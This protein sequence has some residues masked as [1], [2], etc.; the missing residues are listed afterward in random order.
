[1]LIELQ[2]LRQVVPPNVT[3]HQVIEWYM[4]AGIASMAPQVLPCQPSV[5][6]Q[7]DVGPRLLDGCTVT[8]QG[9][10]KEWLLDLSAS[11]GMTSAV[12][13]KLISKSRTVAVFMF[14][15]L[16]SHQ[17][18]ICGIVVMA[19]AMI[20]VSSNDLHHAISFDNAIIWYCHCSVSRF[21]AVKYWNTYN[22]K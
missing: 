19:Q 22:I 1:M 7:C 14:T 3:E 2:G 9:Q 15:S 16:R 8:T 10:L 6:I 21:R 13:T 5:S 20:L 18:T 11:T 4:T 12:T 17:L